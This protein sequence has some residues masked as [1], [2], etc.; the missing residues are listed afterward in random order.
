MNVHQNLLIVQENWNYIVNEQQL[1]DV[2]T[3]MKDFYFTANDNFWSAFVAH[4]SNIVLN[5]EK[6]FQRGF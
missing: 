5:G 1:K 2:L 3:E 4:I 6:R